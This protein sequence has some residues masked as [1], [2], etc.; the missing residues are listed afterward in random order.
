MKNMRHFTVR[1]FAKAC[2]AQYL[3]P[4]EVLEQEIHGVVIDNRQIEE[5]YLFAA[6]AGERVDGHT[7]IPSAF[8]KG[9]I[10]ALSEQKLENPSGPYL[11]V[12]NTLQALK[13]AAEAYRKTLTLPVV[14]ITGSV[15]KTSTK[16]MISSILSQ[17]YSVLKTP[18]NL[19]NEIGLPLTVFQID[20]NHEVAVL[21]LGMNHFG[22]MHRLSKIA[23]PDYCVFT[24]IR[25]VHLEFLGTRDGVFKAKSELLDF[26]APDVKIFINGDDDKLIALKDRAVT[27]GLH[28]DDQIWA[29]QIEN[30]GL[31]G[32]RCCIHTP[33]GDI[34]PVIPLPGNHMVYNACAGTSVGL[35]LGLTLEEISH[36]IEALKAIAGRGHVIHASHYT[37]LDDCYNAGPDSM[38]GALDTLNYALTRKVAVLGDM[39]ELGTNSEALHASVGTH[40]ADLHID[41]LVTIGVKSRA[42]HEAAKQAAP[43]T[44]CIHYE[45]KADFLAAAPQILKEQDA[46]L[47]KASNAQKFKELVSALQE[48]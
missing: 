42:I 47:L 34:T 48:M 28:S 6:V 13:D 29:D 38:K 17:K 40:M 16:E 25:D 1:Q 44:E 4:E 14:A 32:V 3:G 24:N 37:L 33:S 7:F 26:A 23:R 22:E 19:N 27:F 31:D 43:Q 18:G 5:G 45:T 20:T 11:L 8:E 9:A 35:A 2:Q 10:C 30:L 12:E 21:E 46:I 36:G 15:G 39:G 41:L